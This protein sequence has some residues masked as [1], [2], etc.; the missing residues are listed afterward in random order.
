[1]RKTVAIAR[2]E[3]SV[4]LTTATGY[5]GFG[6]YAFLMGLVFASSIN[7]YQALTVSYLNQQQPLLLER[8]NFNDAIIAPMFSAGAWMYL[9]FVP[10]LTMRSF[11]EEKA[12]HTFELLL[13]TPISSTEIVLGKFGGAAAMVLIMTGIPLIFPAILHAYGTTGGGESSVEWLPVFSAVGFIGLMGMSFVAIG[14]LASSMCQSQVTAALATFGVLLLGYL[15]PYFSNRLDGNWQAVVAYLSPVAHL[16]RGL[17]GRV[18]LQ[19]IVFFMSIVVGGLILTQ[20]SVESH[21]WR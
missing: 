17:Q 10:F 15:L 7:Q 5:A 21:R 1:M 11:A 19:D 4:F 20:R 14:L 18:L 8:L 16:S 12:Q 13:T 2:K 3:L 9:F 6:A